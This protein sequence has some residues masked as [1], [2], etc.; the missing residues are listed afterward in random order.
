VPCLV[1]GQVAGQELDVL[2]ASDDD[3]KARVA[4]LVE[5]EGLRPVDAGPLHRARQLEQTGFL[6]VALQDT[7]GT[8]FGSALKIVTP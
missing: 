3:A 1:D 4:G 8:G 7:L 2:L 6:H 5:A